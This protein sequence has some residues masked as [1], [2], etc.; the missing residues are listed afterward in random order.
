MGHRVRLTRDQVLVQPEAVL[1]RQVMAYAHMRGW[2]CWHDRATNG[3]RRCYSCG[4]FLR[5]P[6]NAPGFPDLVLVRRPQVIIAELK[7]EGEK[8]SSQQVDWLD[9]L[10][11]C[12][13]DTYVW[14]PSDWAAIQ[15]ILR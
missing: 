14:R 11:A 9:E 12:G 15:E 6:R 3:P 2:H 10:R 13:I 8:P 1:L 5:Q 4:I 7:A